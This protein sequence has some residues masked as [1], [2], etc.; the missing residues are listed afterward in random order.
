LI[1][2]SFVCIRLR[3]GVRPSTKPLPLRRV[4]Q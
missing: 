2:L 3:I 4:A 1:S